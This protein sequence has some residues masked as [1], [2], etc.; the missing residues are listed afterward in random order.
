MNTVQL[1]NPPPEPDAAVSAAMPEADLAGPEGID[2]ED[3]NVVPAALAAFVAAAGHAH[4][5]VAASGHYRAIVAVEAI[6]DVAAALVK[7]TTH[8]TPYAGDLSRKAGTA[9]ARAEELLAQA[10]TGFSDARH[11]LR[12]D[13]NSPVEAAAQST[14]VDS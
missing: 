12:L 13:Q 14:G 2:M 3:P 10:R 7:I 6:E 4:T 1:Q 9:M 5:A 8:V 11:H